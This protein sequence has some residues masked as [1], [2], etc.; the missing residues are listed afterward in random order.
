[1]VV[2]SAFRLQHLDGTR[3]NSAATIIAVEKCIIVDMGV[4]QA[5]RSGNGA[6]YQNHSFLECCNSLGI[7]RDLTA[8]YTPQQ[9]GLVESALWKSYKA[10]H[11]ARLGVS[12][13]YPEI[14]F[15]GVRS[16][17]DA[18]ASNLVDIFTSFCLRVLQ[19]VGYG[20]K[21]RMALPL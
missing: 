8:P 4:P 10:G 12:N 21:R 20:G 3:F 5:F 9:D 13:I 19:S 18:A 15:E 1:M 7:R 2:D 11:V 6:T 14:R 17:T 16:S